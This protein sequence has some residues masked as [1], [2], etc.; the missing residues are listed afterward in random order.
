MASLLVL[1]DETDRPLGTAEKRKAHREGQLHR[2]FSVFIFD[3]SGRLLLQQRS[4]RKYHSGGLWS[5]ACCSHPFPGEDAED[6]ARRRL[7]QEMGFV[8]Q[9][10]P[11]FQRTYRIR[12]GPLL[13]EHE[14]NHVFVGVA[15]NPVVTPHPEEVTNWAW[16][17]P[18][19]LRADVEDRPYR[20]TG[21]FR[22]LLDEAL[23][24]A[25]TYVFSKD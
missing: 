1:V 8:C 21:W 17:S 12:V 15:D 24:S 13:I 10:Q 3:S 7:Q 23:S 20:Y 4:P 18:H 5:N 19:A 22:L 25:P 11:A 16:V 6:A 14:Y 9:L 2:A